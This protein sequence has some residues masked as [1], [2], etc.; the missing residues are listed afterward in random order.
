MKKII[1]LITVT[2]TLIAGVVFTGCG[3]VKD[4]AD[5]VEN[6]MT[7]VSDKVSEAASDM[8]DNGN[9]KDDDGLIGNGN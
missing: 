3:M 6:A 2:L 5:T 4:A 7:D 8:S 9:I 1:A